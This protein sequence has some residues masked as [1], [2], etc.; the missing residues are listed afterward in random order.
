MS[1]IQTHLSDATLK[2]KR[3]LLRADLNIPRTKTGAIVNDFRLQELLP[4]INLIQK[5]GGK[6]IL[7]THSG[8]P[9]KPAEQLSTSHFVS[10]FQKNGY[11][12]E[13]AKD[14]SQ[15]FTLSKKRTTP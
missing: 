14:I 12:A 4:T 15:A 11:Q 7:L 6:V 8:R 2:D 1:K 13:F 3:V 9:S 10:W 5:K